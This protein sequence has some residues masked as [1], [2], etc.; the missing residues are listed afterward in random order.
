MGAREDIHELRAVIATHDVVYGDRIK[1]LEEERE[2]LIEALW[3]VLDDM[4]S[5]GK[6]VCG[7][8]KAEARYAL[9]YNIDPELDHYPLDRAISV[10]VEIG[11]YESAEQAYARL[12]R[13]K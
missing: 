8:T 13:F 7:G 12:E 10:L 6:S 11:D 5:E 9:G 2:M 1:R 3:Q 4:G